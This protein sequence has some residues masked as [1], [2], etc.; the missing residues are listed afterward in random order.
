MAFRPFYSLSYNIRDRG[1][2]SGTYQ[3]GYTASD[4]YHVAGSN[5]SVYQ[6]NFAHSLL[7]DRGIA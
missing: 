6:Y 3:R 1:C 4:L 2:L 7:P 5:G